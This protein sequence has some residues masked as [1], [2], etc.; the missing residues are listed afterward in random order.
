MFLARR[1]SSCWPFQSRMTLTR[2]LRMRA[3]SQWMEW[4]LYTYSFEMYKCKNVKINSEYLCDHFWIIKNSVIGHFISWF[5]HY[6]RFFFHGKLY[7]DLNLQYRKNRL[8]NQNKRKEKKKEHI[9]C[10]FF[11]HS[12]FPSLSFRHSLHKNIHSPTVHQLFLHSLPYLT[13]HFK[14][15]ANICS[16][17]SQ[18]LKFSSGFSR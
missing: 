16:S 18:S 2:V 11:L 1:C 17:A 13:F 3:I 12:F 8:L 9:N 14:A 10:S 15:P 4:Y 5:N 7:S 6:D